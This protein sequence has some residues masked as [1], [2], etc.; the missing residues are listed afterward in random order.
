[1]PYNHDAN[2]KK[3]KKISLFL[4]PIIFIGSYAVYYFYQHSLDLSEIKILDKNVKWV[5]QC[6]EQSCVEYPIHYVQ[7]QEESFTTS[8]E[9]YQQLKVGETYLASIKGWKVS[10]SIRKLIR[11]Y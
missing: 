10:G 1:M 6:S 4:F 5:E 9:I 8:E 11:V 2:F 7:C 3:L